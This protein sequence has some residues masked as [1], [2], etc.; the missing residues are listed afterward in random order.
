MHIAIDNCLIEVM[1]I[2]LPAIENVTLIRIFFRSAAIPVLWD[3]DI[4]PER[5][6][7]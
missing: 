4:P 7:H 6:P 3:Y 1:F 2:I 5:R